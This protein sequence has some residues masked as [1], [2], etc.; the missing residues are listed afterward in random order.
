MANI[1]VFC[2]SSSVIDEVYKKAA[3]E[4]G[5][6]LGKNGHTLIYGGSKL[7]LMGVLSSSVKKNGGK[8]IGIIP[9]HLAILSEGEDELIKA[10]NMYHRKEMMEIKSDAFIALCGGV[11][12]LNEIFEIIVG[13]QLKIHKKPITIINTNNYYDDIIK[14]LNKIDNEGFGNL[15]F[16]IE[17]INDIFHI[18]KT[19]KEAI[20]YINLQLRK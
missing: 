11:G 18:S 7:G 8:V 14:Q 4:L 6:L 3:S 10:R 2:S 20:E 5:E 15:E 9:E 19:P 12:T 13:K 1:C 17:E 16:D